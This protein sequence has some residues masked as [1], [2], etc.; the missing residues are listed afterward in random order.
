MLTNNCGNVDDTLTINFEETKPLK[1]ESKDFTNIRENEDSKENMND[2][3]VVE[4][5][6]LKKQNTRLFKIQ[7]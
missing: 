6:K 7:V 1:E 2:S 5:S 4:N 3:L